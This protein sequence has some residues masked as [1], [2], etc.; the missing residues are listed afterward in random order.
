MKLKL[1]MAFILIGIFSFYGLTESANADLNNGLI[2]HY[3]FDSDEGGSVSDQSTSSYNGTVFGA[4]FVNNGISGG[5]YHFDG[6]D[7]RIIVGNMGYHSSGT[8]SFW[9]N[10]DVVENWRNPFSTEYA[11]W[12]DCM[13]FEESS[14]GEFCI[15]ALGMGVGQ[16]TPSLEAD[17][18]YHVVYAWDN[19]N[20]YGYLNGKL[21]FTTPHPDPDSS[22]HPNIPNNAAY[23]KERSM[24][25]RNVVIGNGYST[26]ANRHWKGLV[27]EVKIYDRVL[28]SNEVADLHSQTQSSL[29]LYYTFDEDESGVVVDKSGNGNDAVI[30]GSPVIVNGLCGKAFDFDKVDYVK[31]ASNPLAGAS[32]FT[33]S[34]WFKTAVPTNNYKLASGA[35]W[36]GG[37]NASGWIVGTHY[38]EGWGDNQI[39]GIRGEPD[40]IR[41]VAFVANEW[42]HL[43]LTYDGDYVREYINGV[44]AE[45]VI[46]TGIAVGTGRPLEV[47]AWSQYSGLNYEGLVDEFRVYGKALTEGEVVA[48]YEK[49]QVSS[50]MYAYVKSLIHPVSGMAVSRDGE[51]F[52][53]VYKNALAAIAFIHEG[54][55]D[56][57]EEIFDVFQDYYYANEETFEGFSQCW[58]P[59]TGLP[60][61]AIPNYWEGDNAFLLLALN[62]Y[63]QT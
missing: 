60:N 33:I 57:A 47:G 24:D 22:V 45:E 6:V 21:V 39:G 23:W 5:A 15:G 55:L 18:W 44:L 14:T 29:I 46:G 12:D 52:T 17:K 59:S 35:Y 54:D 27:D 10:A 28:L 40:W 36:Y 53:T 8:I 30:Y 7:D 56:L 62:Y 13:R 20:G 19:A 51:D 11:S 32:S 9:M 48:L 2:M 43:V 16:F 25:F 61:G 49:V 31:A 38:P 42:N 26:S 34:M 37:N 3:S 41:D 58:I 1:L 50:R 4:S 63:S